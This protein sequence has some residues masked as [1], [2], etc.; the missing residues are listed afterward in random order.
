MRYCGYYASFVLLLTVLLIF[1]TIL[2]KYGKYCAKL[3]E[4]P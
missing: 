3:L 2:V 1:S 4:Q